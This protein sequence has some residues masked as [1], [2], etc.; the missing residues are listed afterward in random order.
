M[1]TEWPEEVEAVKEECPQEKEQ[2]HR[3]HYI[4]DEKWNTTQAIINATY[5]PNPVGNSSVGRYEACKR[6]PFDNVSTL[7]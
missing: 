1:C 2:R 3:A 7:A 6:S 5:Q 4:S